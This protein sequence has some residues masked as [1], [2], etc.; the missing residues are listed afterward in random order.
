MALERTETLARAIHEDYVRKQRE[1][2]HDSADNPPMVAWEELPEHLRESNRR[3]AEGIAAKLR[4]IGC[5]IVP[6]T[7][8]LHDV[9][10]FDPSELERLARLEH[11]RWWHERE[12][13][14]WTYS[15]KKDIE[16]KSSP[17]LIPYD[18]LPDEIRE[19]DR[20]AVK[21][22][23]DVLARAGLMIARQE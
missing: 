17:Y 21:A 2:G 7:D 6:L 19:L 1:Y 15:P 10:T 22:I 9:F 20:N 5:G 11:E 14:G 18:E 23:P 13:T 3:Q 4:A 12:A 16:G 8:G